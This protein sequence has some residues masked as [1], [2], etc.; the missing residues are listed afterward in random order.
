MLL[1]TYSA[2]KCFANFD[3]FIIYDLFRFFN[4][5]FEIY[6]ILSVCNRDVKERQKSLTIRKM[7]Y[8]GQWVQIDV[9]LVPYACIVGQTKAEGKK[10]YQY[11]AIDEYLGYRYLKV[12]ERRLLLRHRQQKH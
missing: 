8:P 10:F 4:R 3:I 9:K 1:L 11:T 7:R 6:Y 2:E 5:I 12:F